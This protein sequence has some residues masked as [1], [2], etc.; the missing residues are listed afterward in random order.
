MAAEA[1]IPEPVAVERRPGSFTL[2]PRCAISAPPAL[3]G[4]A[5][6]FRRVLEA[7]TG[8]TVEPAAT[9]DGAGNGGGD[10]SDVGLAIEGGL[11]GAS[12]PESYRLVVD[13]GGIHLAGADPAGVARGLET[14]RQLLPADLY[15]AAPTRR[16]A[17][18]VTLEG[19]EVRDRP[20]FAWRGVHLDVA[21]HFMP[22]PFLLRLVDLAA[23]HKLNVLHLHLTDD[24]GWRMEIEKYPLL[25]EVGAWRRESMAGHYREQR[26]DG[27]PHGG[28]YTKDDL[29]EVV[30]YA[31]ERHIS[32]LP[33]I[34]MPGHMA[35]A[36]AA[37]PELGDGPRQ[38]VRT[39]W[40]ISEHVLNLEESTVRFCC[41]VLD[42]VAEVF[43]FAYLHV[44]GDECPTAEWRESARARQLMDELG[45]VRPREFQGWFTE[46][47]SGHV[48][49]LGRTLV[50]WDEILEGGAPE[51]AVVM[52]WRGEE[53]G[54]EAAKAGHDVVMAPEQWL[55]LD[56]ANADDPAEPVAIRAAT[57]LERVHSYRPVPA[58]LEGHRRHVLGA[59]CQLWTEYVATPEH[60]EYMYFPRL[61]AFAETVWSPLPEGGR[62]FAAFRRRLSHHLR[63]LDALGVNYRPL[64]GPTPGQ[65][66]RWLDP[67]AR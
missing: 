2:G 15:R 39:A 46:R 51:G 47:I 64:E 36:L 34:D 40:G 45:F 52:S 10:G 16:L 29:R 13:E 37:Y 33:E 25:T 18:P 27:R 4:E 58:A 50:G 7:A 65:A 60:A 21:R 28:F 12:R 49:S 55:Y 62:D 17:E 6:W 8:W 5:A 19:V 31:A 56:W 30:A 32:V 44:G 43:P 67:G 22:K 1:I 24:Q 66:A 9:G 20:A 35:A 11:A 54:I 42:E 38:E 3:A 14:L 26:F 59:Q 41:D 63:R 23:L 61:S 48:A 53:G 57:T